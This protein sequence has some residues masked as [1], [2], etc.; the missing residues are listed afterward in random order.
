MRNLNCLAPHVYV[1]FEF[2][3]LLDENRGD[4]I[5]FSN[6]LISQSNYLLQR[7]SFYQRTN[8][9]NVIISHLQLSFIIEIINLTK[10]FH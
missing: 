8:F 5:N 2:L 4:R 10:L 7:N 6:E 9:S 1:T 3:D